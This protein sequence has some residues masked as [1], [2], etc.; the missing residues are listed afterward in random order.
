MLPRTLD[1][2]SRVTLRRLL[3]AFQ[4]ES[5]PWADWNESAQL[6]LERIQLNRIA[7]SLGPH[8]E[9]RH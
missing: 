5:E 4:A 2:R 1:R 7:R 8:G 3:A 6:E 9:L